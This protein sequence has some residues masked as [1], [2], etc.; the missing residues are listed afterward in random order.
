MSQKKVLVYGSLAFDVIFSVPE[1]FRKSIPLENGEIRNFNATYIANGKKE[2]PGGTAGNIAYWLSQGGVKNTVFSAWGEDF[3]QKKYREK[4]EKLG[5]EIRGAQGDFT[6]HAYMVSDPLHQQLI[7]WQP[8]AYEQNETQN[9]RD[10]LSEEEL[11]SFDYVIFSPGSPSSIKKHIKEFRSINKEATI[12]FDPGQV[13]PFF[14]ASDF[15]EI[16]EQSDILIGNDIEWKHFLDYGISGEKLAIETLG[17]RGVRI[18]NPDGSDQHFQAQKVDHV[19]ETTGAGDAF[20]GGLLSVL[21]IGGSLEEGI[22]K[23]ME[24]GAQCVQLPSGQK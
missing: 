2:Y 18:I 19:V 20:R 4:L 14:A 15:C 6:A 16:Y 5:S 17:E 22:V 10:H 3:F 23:G 12:F 13:S 24:F 11:R 21:A 8:N 1:D 9:L 7:I